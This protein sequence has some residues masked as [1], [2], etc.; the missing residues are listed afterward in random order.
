MSL[1]TNAWIQLSLLYEVNDIEV[2]PDHDF[3]TTTIGIAKYGCSHQFEITVTLGIHD[4]FKLFLL[5][6][7]SE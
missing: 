4:Q 6:P 7:D 2:D 3:K 1:T 5:W